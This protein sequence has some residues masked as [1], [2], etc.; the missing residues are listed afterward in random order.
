MVYIAG[1]H[2][3]E[4]K[5]LMQDALLDR[6]LLFDEETARARRQGIADNLREAEVWADQGRITR[7]KKNERTLAPDRGRVIRGGMDD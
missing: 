7:W 5:K 2:H 3:S 4:Y 1:L 6:G